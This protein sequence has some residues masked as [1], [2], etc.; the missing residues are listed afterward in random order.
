MKSK[1]ASLGIVYITVILSVAFQLIGLEARGGQEIY[2]EVIKPRRE[3]VSRK[4]ALP[5]SVVPFEKADLFA[6]VAGYIKWIKVDIG[7]WAKK[8][9][10]LAFI[11][12]PELEAEYN[13]L[14]AELASRQAEYELQQLIY[15][16][17]KNLRKEDAATME[18]L[19]IARYKMEAA[20]AVVELAQAKLEKVAALLSYREIK[21]PFNGVIARRFLDTGALVQ[22]ATTTANPS[23]IVTVMY[24]DTV[25]IL[26]DIPEPDVPFIKAGLPAS[27]S[28]D[29]LPGKTF[30]G[31]I[32]RFASSLNLATRTM[33][34]AIDIPNPDRAL[35]P[36]M[37]GYV[38]LELSKHR[39]A[40]T[41]PAECL[42]IENYKRFLYIVENG[43]V[44]KVA[45]ETGI[46][47][48]IT[49]EIAEGLKGDED[50]ILKG[51]AAVS[52]G[53]RVRIYRGT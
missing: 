16:M 35:L 24:I 51:K 22:H 18:D 17:K 46:D 53:S 20:K 44:K 25:R 14:K 19:E 4:I 26:V 50:V 40:I 1:G 5:G 45:V 3:D 32:S 33:R 21:A 9:D 6:Q 49:A 2:V 12:V 37:Y 52:E 23:P 38:S 30:A 43:I 13:Q 28:I 7:D 11:C 48:G 39:N 41:V 10:V 27:I 8:D 42:V 31:E 47:T 34:T 15:E 29:A 36:G